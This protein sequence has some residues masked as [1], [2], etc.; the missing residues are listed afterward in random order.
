[1]KL[2]KRHEK[3]LKQ[4]FLDFRQTSEFI[5]NPLIIDRAEGLYYWDIEGTRYFDGIGGIF[6]ATLGHR[7]PRVMDAMKRQMDKV[8]FTPPLHG[9]SDVALEFV[10]KLSTVSPDNLDFI[11]DDPVDDPILGTA[12]REDRSEWLQQGRI[13]GSSRPHG[14]KVFAV[15]VVEERDEAGQPSLNHQFVDRIRLLYP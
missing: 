2:S 7:H 13:G 10:E 5:Q 6:V 1:M 4:T 8:T 11:T 3:L 12:D 14:A 9:I 15:V